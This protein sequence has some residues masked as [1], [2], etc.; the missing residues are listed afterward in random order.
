[1][2]TQAHHRNQS[3]APEGPQLR[4]FGK[5]LRK[6]YRQGVCQNLPFKP[7]SSRRKHV[8]TS[9]SSNLAIDGIQTVS[10]DQSATNRTGIDWLTGNSTQI[11][12]AQAV[13]H[14]MGM[15]QWVSATSMDT[16]PVVD[17]SL[18][19]SVVPDMITKIVMNKYEDFQPK[20]IT[21]FDYEIRP[22]NDH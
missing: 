11:I 17:T 2:P 9:L 16:G 12:P 3:L 5:R 19:L 1:M 4:K 10:D 8:F 14:V 13:K 22:T 7:R 6:L 20:L 15:A 18:E 21:L